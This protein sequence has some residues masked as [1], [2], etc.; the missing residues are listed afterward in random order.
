MTFSPASRQALHTGCLQRQRL[1][2]V[3]E[4]TAQHSTACLSP[5]GGAQRQAVTVR[6]DCRRRAAERGPDILSARQSEE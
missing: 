4:R 2:P 1:L 5:G 6:P 3:C